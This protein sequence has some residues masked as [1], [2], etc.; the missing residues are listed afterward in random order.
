M[1]SDLI[2]MIFVQEEDA[3]KARQALE[4]MR[5]SGLLGLE[6]AALVIKDSTGR[7][8]VHQRWELPAYPRKP[9]SHLPV[10]FADAIFRS[11]SR[12]GVQKLAD[13][14][15]DE[16]FLKDV[17]HE[18]G[19]SSSALLIYV[20]HDSLVDTRRLLDTLG[21]FRGTLHHTTF[22]ARVEGVI[23]EEANT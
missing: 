7:A 20:P 19:P 8:A 11:T 15:L 3:L 14:G 1:N 4:I 9:S 2:I 12:E 13:A 5:D 23:L 22:P 18:L 16:R 6:N 10:I 17:T 21:L